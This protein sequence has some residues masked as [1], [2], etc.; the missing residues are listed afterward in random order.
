MPHWMAAHLQGTGRI[1]Q[2]IQGAPGPPG[3]LI[4]AGTRPAT[5]FLTGLAGS[6]V[7][8]IIINPNSMRRR[9]FSLSFSLSILWN[10]GPT[11]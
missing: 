2:F 9:S 5:A 1:K 4:K 10:P 11:P 7:E 6:A 8:N 3:Q